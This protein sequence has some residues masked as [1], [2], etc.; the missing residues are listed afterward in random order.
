MK[1][2]LALLTLFGTL[3]AS[4]ESPNIVLPNQRQIEWAECE[5]GLILH[6]DLQCFNPDYKWRNFG[7]HPPASIFNPTELDTEQWM[8]AAKAIGAK[9]IVFVAKHC[10]GFSLWPTKAHEYSVKNSPWK[11]GKG[12]IVREFVDSCR[13]NSIK[14]GIYASTSANGL[15]HVDRGVVAKGAPVSQSEY[16]KMVS[17]QLEELW[18]NYGELF[19]VWFD[20]GVLSKANGGERILPLLKKLQPN[21]IAFQGPYMFENLIRWV[22]NEDGTAPY[23]CWATANE[24]TDSDGTVA[25]KG[26]HGDPNAKFWCPGEADFPLRWNRA[27]Q[28]GWFWKA[29]EDDKMFTVEQLMKKYETSV[30][31]NTNMLVGVVIDSRGLV[32]DADMKRLEEWGAEIRKMYGNPIASKS[33]S[34][35]NSFTITFDS[36]KEVDRAIIQ[37]DI[38]FGERVLEYALEGLEDGKWI[39]LSKGTCV[40]HKRIDKFE[41]KKISALRFTAT[42]TK[43]EPKIKTLLAFEK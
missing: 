25:V 39:P 14:P 10:S 30:G 26:L 20:G 16:G 42:K 27:F 1:K 4:A 37:E 7:S 6:L 35:E 9:Y 34:G 23:P 22:G 38:K 5:I 40:G 32:P 11:G 41:P 21:A 3:A 12:D 15:F 13:R 28:G 17:T 36:P 33:E 29:G 24:T 43:A 31:R 2:L 8:R 18:S 19:E